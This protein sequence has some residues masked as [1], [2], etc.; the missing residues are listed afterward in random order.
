MTLPIA[1]VR[2]TSEETLIV[3]QH[4]ISSMWIAP[5][6]NGPSGYYDR[7]HVDH[8]SGGLSIFPAHGVF[9]WTYAADA[10]VKTAMREGAAW[11]MEAESEP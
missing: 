11:L 7:I 3:G 8:E 4:G 2:L 10:N 5:D 9:G 6:G 1:A